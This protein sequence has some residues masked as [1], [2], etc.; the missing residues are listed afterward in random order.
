MNPFEVELQVFQSGEFWLAV[1]LP[2]CIALVFSFMIGL[3]RQN[4]GKSAGIS[5]HILI[6]MATAIIG[7]VQLFMYKAQGA[8][9][10]ADNQRLIA[11]VLPGVGFIGAGVIMKGGKTIIGLTTAATIWAT[12]I[13]GLVAGSGYYITATIFGTFLVLFIYLRDMKRGINPFIPHVHHDFLESEI[14]VE[15]DDKRRHA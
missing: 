5:A 11:Q 8:D 14:D 12:A 7:I 1:V 4:I 9:S 10:S 2:L 13:M 3:E 6:G 15:D